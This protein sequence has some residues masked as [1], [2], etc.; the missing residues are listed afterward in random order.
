MNPYCLVSINFEENLKLSMRL[1][2]N[3]VKEKIQ[4]SLKWL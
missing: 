4:L 1:G 2:E 3:V